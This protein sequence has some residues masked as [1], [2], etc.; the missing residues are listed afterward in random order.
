MPRSVE[1]VS[2]AGGF[3]AVS[4][5]DWLVHGRILTDLC[6]ADLA[7]WLSELGFESHDGGWYVETTIEPSSRFVFMVAHQQLR[8]VMGIADSDAEIEAS[9]E[10]VSEA[11]SA[12]GI[13]HSFE[14]YGSAGAMT[15]YLHYNWPLA[16]EEWPLGDSA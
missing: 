3:A 9:A 5:K 7:C 11:L 13:T 8:L 16:D 14:V 1:A 12:L 10:Q 15:A 4:S 2:E 6:S